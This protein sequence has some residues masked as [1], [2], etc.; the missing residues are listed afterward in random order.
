MWLLQVLSSCMNGRSNFMKHSYD[1]DDDRYYEKDNKEQKRNRKALEKKDRSKFKKTDIFQKEKLSKEEKEHLAIGRVISIESEGAILFE[2][3][4]QTYFQAAV[5]GS[6]KYETSQEKNLLTI[7]DFVYFEKLPS[8]QGHIV[9]VLERQSTL[10]RADNFSRRK[11]HLIAANIDQV[12]ITVSCVH[13]ALKTALIDRY[14]I[15]AIRGN[16]QPIVLIT[17]IDLVEKDESIKAIIDEVIT[18]YQN[19]GYTTIGISTVTLQGIDQLKEVMKGKSSV[20]SGQSG[21]GKTSLINLLTGHDFKTQEI[22]EKTM[23]GS[24]TTT[25]AHLV[26][27]T[28]S[29]FCIDTPGIR[30]FGMWDLK[31]EEI[32]QY[33]KE[34]EEQKKKCKFSN[35]THINEPGCA[36]MKAVEKGKIAF[37]RYESYL[38]LMNEEN[39]LEY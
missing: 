32:Q 12:L 6:L 27:L 38:A 5:K 14:I 16:M 4:T 25:K 35:C 9:E 1:H 28:C 33:F 23:K 29:G 39:P 26:P 30:S 37:F 7:G 3:Q 36:V 15:A 31:K 20:F 10:Y 21:V 19:L 17:K 2:E 34:I 24:H 8:L 22:I 11:M 13:P 18:T